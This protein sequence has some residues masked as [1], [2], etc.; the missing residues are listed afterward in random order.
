MPREGHGDWLGCKRN[1]SL[2]IATAHV[3]LSNYLRFAERYSDHLHIIS[4]D[5]GKILIISFRNGSRMEP[6]PITSPQRV[7]LMK[8]RSSFY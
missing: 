7:A 2:D 1:V 6:L 3:L 8:A 4:D 5:G